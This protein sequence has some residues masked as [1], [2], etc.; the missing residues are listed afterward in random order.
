MLQKSYNKISS[1]DFGVCHG[2]ELFMLFRNKRLGDKNE[3]LKTTKDHEMSKKMI[4]LW[5][6]FASKGHPNDANW[7][8]LSKENHQFL[9]SAG[10][11]PEAGQ[12]QNP[13]Q[14]HQTVTRPAQ[15][16]FC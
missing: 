6:S 10:A 5:T 1:Y 14:P 13:S 4:G 7:L 16:G 2:D 11:E 9:S 3:I 8:P 12:P 15:P